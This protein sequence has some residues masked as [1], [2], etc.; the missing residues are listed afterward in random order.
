MKKLVAFTASAALLSAAFL[1]GPPAQAST[2]KYDISTLAGKVASLNGTAGLQIRFSA[3]VEQ[4]AN[5]E[6]STAPGDPI[7]PNLVLSSPLDGTSIAAPAVTVNQD[8]A[9][10]PQ[11]ETAI[12]V[13]PNNPNRVVGGANDYVARTWP[14]SVSGTPCSALGDGYSGSYFS[15]DGGATW[16][17]SASDPTHVGTLIPGV[18][19]LAGGPYDAAGDPALAF[20]SRGVVYYAGL[21]FN[22]ASAPNTVTV[23]R[24]TFDSGGNLG[25]GAPTLINATTSPAVFNDK[26]WIAAD[27]NVASPF[28]DRVYVSWTRFVFNPTT[29]AYVQ[30]PIFFASSS[31]GG[32]TFTAPKSISGN[33]LYDQGSR[34]VVGPDGSL[35]VFFEGATRLATAD[36]TYVV[37]STDGGAN[38]GKPSAISTLVDSEVLRD[39]A[40]RNNSFPAAAAAANGDLYATWTTMMGGASTAVYSKS[41]N[42]GTT[43]SAPARVFSAATRTAE[44]YPA[45]TLTAPSPGGPVEDIF[46]AVD[47]SPNGH[48]YVGSYRGNTVSPWQLCKAGPPPPVGRITCD[49]LGDYIHNTRLDYVVTDLTTSQTRTVSTHPINTRYGFGGAFFGDYTDLS[50][51]SDGTFHALWTDSNNKQDVEWFYGAQ[52]VPTPINQQDVVTAKGNF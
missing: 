43:W 33:V 28:R 39:T 35:Y 24:G 22:R 29:G 32:R 16:C 23:N 52:F 10:A 30:S 11:N 49:V 34:P 40:F 17:C 45:G 44:G 48:V 19:H 9:A 7:T 38:W 47:V 15:N 51:G 41:T 50:V 6:V 20:D 8:T 5:T 26:E 42:A 14:C 3:Y 46:P 37:K 36:S 12:A 25:W 2:P 18:T 4:E 1:L 21:G 13:D 31:D 27:A